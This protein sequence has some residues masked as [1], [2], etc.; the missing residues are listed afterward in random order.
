MIILDKLFLKIKFHICIDT[1]YT[2]VNSVCCTCSCHQKV[3]LLPVVALY[4]QTI[5]LLHFKLM[6]EIFLA[7]I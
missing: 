4:K 7:Y 6:H 3:F 5:S 1:G 2:L